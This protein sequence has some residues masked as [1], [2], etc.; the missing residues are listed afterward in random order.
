M[1]MNKMQQVAKVQYRSVQT[2]HSNVNF[3]F[4][5]SALLRFTV[6]DYPFSIFANFLNVNSRDFFGFDYFGANI[7]VISFCSGDRFTLT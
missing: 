5:L 3:A 6:Y 7:T 1:H 4:S 2:L